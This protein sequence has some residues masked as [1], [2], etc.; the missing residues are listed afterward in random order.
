MCVPAG[1][2][3]EL[4]AGQGTVVMDG[5]PPLPASPLPAS[6]EKL[7]PGG[8]PAYVRAGRPV[9][10]RWSPAGVTHHVEL[11]GLKGDAVLIARE[12][13]APPLRLE[14]PW[15]GT[16]RWRVSARDPRG[17]ESAPSAD[18]LIVLVEK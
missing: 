17:I 12:T 16:Y 14:I 8:D 11:L 3:V 15:I 4:K 2:T 10:L 7:R 13:G 6:P 18:G 1:R 9:E 5:R